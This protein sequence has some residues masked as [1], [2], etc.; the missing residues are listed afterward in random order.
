MVIEKATKRK[1][2]YN[3]QTTP[4]TTPVFFELQPSVGFYYRKTIGRKRKL[5]ASTQASQLV[6]F[7]KFVLSLSLDVSAVQEQNS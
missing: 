2:K 6:N 4:M 1:W 7:I 3:A 5:S